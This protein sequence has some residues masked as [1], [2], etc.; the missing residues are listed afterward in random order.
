M[1]EEEIPGC[2]PRLTV[3]GIRAAAAYGARLASSSLR[4]SPRAG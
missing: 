2:S 4:K 1:S 3:E